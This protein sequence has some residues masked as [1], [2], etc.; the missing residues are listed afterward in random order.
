MNRRA[1]GADSNEPTE[2]RRGRWVWRWAGHS[3][4][5]RQ[6]VAVAAEVAGVAAEKALVGEV[7]GGV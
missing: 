7:A 3:G 4:T 2:E 6:V 1:G 5:G